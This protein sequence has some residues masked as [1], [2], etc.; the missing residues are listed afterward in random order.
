MCMQS[1]VID[2]RQLLQSMC[3]F[4]LANVGSRHTKYLGQGRSAIPGIGAEQI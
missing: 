2:R 3:D 4:G 1:M